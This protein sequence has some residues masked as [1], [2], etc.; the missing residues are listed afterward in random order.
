MKQTLRLL[1]VFVML[2]T[3][4]ALAWAV[5]P[6]DVIDTLGDSDQPVKYY[7]LQGRQITD[8]STATGV[9]IVKRADGTATKVFK[10]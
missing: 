1:A 2:M 4:N 10:R 8:P 7:D 3:S 6:M 9:I 5:D